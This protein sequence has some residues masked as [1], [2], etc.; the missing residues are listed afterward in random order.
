MKQP[1]PIVKLGEVL[2]LRRERIALE[3]GTTYKRITVKLGGLGVVLRDEVDGAAIKTDVQYL[4]RAGQL[5]VSKIDARNGSFGLIPG[6]L[7]GSVVS[8]N[9]LTFDCTL[10]RIAPK[11]I[12]YYVSRPSF[13]EECS[14]ISEGTTNRVPV[15]VEQFLEL[16]IP[17]PPLAEQRWIVA[18]I[19]ELAAQVQEAHSLRQQAAAAIETL[20]R[21]IIT[22]DRKTKNTPMRQLVKMRSPDVVVTPD[23]S[24]QFAGVYSFG[25][26]VFRTTLKSGMDFSYPRLTRL[27][28]GEFVYPKLMAWEGALGVVPPECDGCVVSTEFPVFEVNEDRVFHEVLDVYFRTPSVWPDISGA[29]TGTNVRRRRLNPKDFLDYEMPLPSRETQIVIRKIC[30]E[31]DRLKAL[32]AETATELDA[33]L[34]SLL[35]RAFKGEL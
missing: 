13:W 4:A 16:P 34:P 12:E 23:G 8:G 3:V 18:R 19:E 24:Y 31:V 27:R 1:W 30:A 28:A 20:L 33:L 15:R 2:L 17:L 7:D 10:T 22:H 11:F 9:F 6:A 5:V 25:R 29:S 32:Q 21:T 14:K 26:G 35:D